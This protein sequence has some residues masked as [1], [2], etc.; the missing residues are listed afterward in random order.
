MAQGEFL[1]AGRTDSAVRPAL[2]FADERIAVRSKDNLIVCDEKVLDGVNSS[3]SKLTELLAADP[4]RVRS[5]YYLCNK[6]WGQEGH[7]AHARLRATIKRLRY[8]CGSELGNP[9]NGAI[10]THR[11]VGYYAVKSLAQDYI[12]ETKP[13]DEEY[14]LAD[15]RITLNATRWFVARDDQLLKQ[16]RPREFRLLRV[17]ASKPDTVISYA[18]LCKVFHNRATPAEQ[19]ILRTTISNLRTHLGA[20]LGDP[21][22]GVI[23]TVAGVGYLASRQI[24]A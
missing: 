9:E 16:V 23:K 11:G 22:S 13:G 10:R 20:E 18:S 24:Q 2:L 1:A 12:P 8:A 5:S 7:V 19:L 15:G 21:K 4:D 3:E 17:L 6:L 14:K